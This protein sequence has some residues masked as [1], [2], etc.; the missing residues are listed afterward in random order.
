M[1]GKTEEYLRKNF[2]IIGQGHFDYEYAQS[3]VV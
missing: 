2:I 1:K 3:L